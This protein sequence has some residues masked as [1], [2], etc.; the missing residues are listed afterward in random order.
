MDQEEKDFTSLLLKKMPK[1]VNRIITSRQSKELAKNKRIS[2]E[3]AVY[4]IL[5]ESENK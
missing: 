5:I 4:K 3:Q 1:K 2:K